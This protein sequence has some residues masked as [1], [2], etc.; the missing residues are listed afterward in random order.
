MEDRMFA[1]QAATLYTTYHS[2]QILVHR[3]FILIPRMRALSRPITAQRSIQGQKALSICLSSA[4]AAAHILDVQTKRGMLNITNVVHISFVCAGVFLVHLWDL[5][6]Q[7]GTHSGL[8]SAEGRAHMSHDISSVMGELGDVMAH[9]E[10]ISSKWELA[11]E[12]L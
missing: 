3:P 9:L 8:I 4:R 5:I 7:Y 10:D 12:M 1:T 2:V 11:R 6:R